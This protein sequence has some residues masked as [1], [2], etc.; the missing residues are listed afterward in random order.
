[1]CADEVDE[2]ADAQRRRKA[3]LLRRGPDRDPCGRHTRVATE[4]LDLA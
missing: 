3:T 1:M 2:L 4:Q